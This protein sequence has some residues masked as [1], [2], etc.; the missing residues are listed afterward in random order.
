MK[1]FQ[2]V[3]IF[4]CF[5]L[6]LYA[7][8]SMLLNIPKQAEKDKIFIEAEIKPS[9]DFVKNFNTVN[10]RL[11]NYREY[12]T[13]QREFHNDYNSDLTQEVDSLIPG[14]GTIRYIR[15]LTD[16]TSNDYDKFENADWNKDFAIGVWRGSWTEYYF[17][18]TDSY[19]KNN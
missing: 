11:P 18:W 10:G 4:I 8:V 5:A 16:L 13:W 19:D 12:Y 2:K 9:V 14:F 7:G 15:K 17:S 6:G 3:L 1:A